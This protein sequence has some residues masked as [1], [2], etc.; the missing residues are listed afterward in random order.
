[1]AYFEIIQSAAIDADNVYAEYDT[2]SYYTAV[3]NVFLNGSF[4]KNQNLLVD[5]YQK[6]DKI[7]FRKPKW[8]NW[9]TR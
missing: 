3:K 5:K 7:N 6:K 1:M 8:R 4:N 9:Q 2:E